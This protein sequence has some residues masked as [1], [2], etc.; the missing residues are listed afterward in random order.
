MMRSAYERDD[1]Y[2]YLPDHDL[3]FFYSVDDT[4]TA[5][6]LQDWFPQGHAMQRQSYQ[7][8]DQYMLYE[9][10]ALGDA[11]FRDWLLSGS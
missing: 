3:L 6:T 11:A 7:W 5:A 2:R 10:P 9:V 8:D 1:A 4:T